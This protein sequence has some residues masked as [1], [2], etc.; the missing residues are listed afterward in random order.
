MMIEIIG[1]P[2]GNAPE[3]I[4]QAW[5]GMKLPAV[6]RD[7]PA[8][9][10]DWVRDGHQNDGGYCVEGPVAMAALKIHNEVAW[11]WWQDYCPQL[12]LGGELIFKADVCKEI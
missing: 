4:R 8:R 5:I 10:R 1:T 9:K 2:P 12:L 3:N 6:G 7:L 11:A